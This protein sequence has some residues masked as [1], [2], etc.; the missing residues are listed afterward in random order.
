MINCTVLASFTSPVIIHTSAAA[1]LWL[2]P[3]SLA[4]SAAYKAMKLPE[5]T[6]KKLAK[7]TAGLFASIVV[8]MILIW[9]ALLL[10]DWLILQRAVL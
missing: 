10:F 4:I 9:I 7:E 1:L 3:L 5:L 2:L 6:W 8:F